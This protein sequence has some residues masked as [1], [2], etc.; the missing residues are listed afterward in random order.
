MEIKLKRTTIKLLLL[1]IGSSL[2]FRFEGC[3]QNGGI[4]IPSGV[5]QLTVSVKSNDTV[6]DNPANIIITEAKALIS[7]VELE[8]QSDGKDELQQSGPLVFHFNTEGSI[9]ELETQYIIMD[10]YTKIKFQLHKPGES[11][12]PTDSEFKEGDSASQRYSFIVKG[13]YNGNS[14]VYKSKQSANLVIDLDKVE[15]LNLDRENITVLFNKLKWFSNGSVGID[16]NDPQYESL[17]DNN[18]KTSFSKAFLDNNK[19]G[20]PD[21]N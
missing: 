13:T 3:D 10:N 16:P 15:N 6:S 20:L 14:F 7:N 5:S 1:I 2:I 19:D 9:E 21:I 4:T 17:I 18:I 8:R 11:E 12:T